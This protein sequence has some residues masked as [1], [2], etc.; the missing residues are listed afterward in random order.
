[1]PYDEYVSNIISEN[2][3]Y[4]SLQVPNQ[5][6]RDV[7]ECP[8]TLRGSPG[9]ATRFESGFFVLV[10]SPNTLRGSDYRPTAVTNSADT[11][12]D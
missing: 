1:M 12:H 2:L 4:D 10:D 5:K 8:N 11:G 9:A 6:H 3:A 7:K